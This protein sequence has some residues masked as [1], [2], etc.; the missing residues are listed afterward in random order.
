MKP[1]VTHS[2]FTIERTYPTPPEKVFA[3]FADPQKKRRWYADGDGRKAEVF[4]MDF[5]VGGAE[6]TQSRLGP[7]TPFPGLAIVSHS[8]YQDIQPNRR[9]VFAHTMTLGENRISASLMTVEFVPVDSG[10]R[11]LFTDQSAFFEGADGPKMR[12][13]GW[14]RLIDGITPEVLEATNVAA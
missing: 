7:T 13:D 4:E 11:L 6:R 5:R 1:T 2:T 14:N 3:A 12:E 8:I 10:T 9:I